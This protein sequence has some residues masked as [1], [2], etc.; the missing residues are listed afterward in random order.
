[1]VVYA[2]PTY[3]GI[4]AV[5][6]DRMRAFASAI[7]L[8]CLASVGIATGTFL[9]GLLSDQLAATHGANSLRIALIIL[10][11]YHPHGWPFTISS[12]RIIWV[13]R[14]MGRGTRQF[15]EAP[16]LCESFVLL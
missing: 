13:S 8:F 15:S 2:G 5:V 9:A 11:P 3:A 16:V 14:M 12:L 7:T 4:Q 6:D 10:T 1:M